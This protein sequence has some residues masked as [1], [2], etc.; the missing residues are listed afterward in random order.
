MVLQISDPEVNIGILGYQY[1][2]YYIPL[3]FLV[4]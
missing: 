1:I 2:Q 3:M 4:N